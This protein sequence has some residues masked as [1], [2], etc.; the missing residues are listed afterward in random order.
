MCIRD[1]SSND[2]AAAI[3]PAMIIGAI[4]FVAVLL[5]SIIPVIGGFISDAPG[6]STYVQGVVIF[7][8]SFSGALAER[9]IPNSVLPGFWYIVGFA[10]IAIAFTYLLAAVVA[11]LAVSVFKG[12]SD[13]ISE[14]V[15]PVIITFAGILPLLMYAS[16]FA[17]NIRAATQ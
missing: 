8:F 9:H 6:V 14:L 15:S 7:W 3:V 13:A 11:F 2:F 17:A 16:A 1:R 10:A 5:L 4:S 12:N